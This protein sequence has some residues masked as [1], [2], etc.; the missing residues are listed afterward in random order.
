MVTVTRVPLSVL[1]SLS[2]GLRSLHGRAQR[3]PAA[4]RAPSLCPGGGPCGLAALVQGSRMKEGVAASTSSTTSIS[5][6]RRAVEQLKMEACMDRVKVSAQRA[7]GPRPVQIRLLGAQSTPRVRVTGPQGGPI[8][9]GGPQTGSCSLR[10]DQGVKDEARASVSAPC[11]DFE[12]RQR[13]VLGDRGLLGCSSEPC[14]CVRCAWGRLE[15]RPP[16]HDRCC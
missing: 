6:A 5:Q 2:P 13:H 1:P 15:C 9:Q 3:P 8:V 7:L 11:S 14:P 16:P 12:V 10:S 4:S